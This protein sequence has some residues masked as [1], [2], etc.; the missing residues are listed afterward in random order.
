MK[1]EK[2]PLDALFTS[3]QGKW[4]IEEPNEG[5][6]LRFL[7]KLDGKKKKK[8]SYRNYLAIAASVL[9]FLGVF[10]SREIWSPAPQNKM[11]AKNTE[12]QHYFAAVIKQELAEIKNDNSPESQALVK[13]ALRRLEAMD[14]DYQKLMEE[15]SRKG[16][17]E[18]LVH[19]M[20]TNLQTRITFLENVSRQIATIKK[21]KSSSHENKTI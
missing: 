18:Q 14:Q 1:D 16:E 9:L 12:T 4:D 15:M 20:V 21:L 2:D 10:M 8:V 19:A 11:S 13:D 3:L 5:H 17:N 6:E 7:Q